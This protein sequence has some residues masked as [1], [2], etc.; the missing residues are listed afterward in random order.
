MAK[1]FDRV[2]AAKQLTEQISEFLIR[3]DLSSEKILVFAI[4]RGGV[5]VGD[6]IASALHLD[7]DIVVTKKIGAPYN[8]ELAIGAV[9]PDGSFYGNQHI[10][11]ALKI[12]SSY[13]DSEKIR[14][15]KEIEHRMYA[16]RGSIEY[17]V[18]FEDKIVILVD[19]GIATGATMIAA[20]EWLKREKHPKKLIIA[21]PVAPKDEIVE[22]LKRIA[23]Y[24][25]ILQEIRD[26][27]AVGQFYENFQQ[28][29]DNEV[30]EIL[31]KYL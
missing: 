15:K 8:P 23:D 26:F 2:D 28:V 22:I 9:M 4:P 20:V 3:R 16:F 31:K 6:I 1:F 18:N 13:I 21:V 17:N 27:Q 10:I 7:L 11:N 25:I 14:Q 24:V 29:G 5:V 19:D 12:D 30:K